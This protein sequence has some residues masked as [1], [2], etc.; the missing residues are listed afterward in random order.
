MVSKKLPV[1]ILGTG[2]I[3][4]DLLLKVLRSPV[5]ECRLFAGRNLSSSGMTKASMLNVPVSAKGVESI[6]DLKKE[7]GLVFDATS[8]E[9][10]IKHAP[11]FNR[12]GIVAVDLT[13]AKVGQMCVPAVNLDQC[14]D[15]PN[16]NMITCGGQ[17]SI[18]LAYA[19]A[20][21][22]QAIQYI[23]TVSSIASRSAG[24]ATRIN[25]DEYLDTTETGLQFFS[26]CPHTKAILNL[27][28]A[29]PCVH[30]QTTVMAKILN[31]DLDATRK[32]VAEMVALIRTY[33]PGYQLLLEPIVENGRLV[34]MVK[35][36][37]LGDY[38]PKYAGNLDIINC[39]AIAFAEALARRRVS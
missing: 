33:V 3:G 32:K 5:L 24:P 25:L 20:Q 31:P 8:A 23:E 19:I 29:Q 2:N 10:H 18:P 16:V 17:A 15:L 9:D 14:L 21:A 22:N 11:L 36:D 4:T 13:P 12:A 39:A 6:L 38:L 27:N 30:M 37:G 7:I 35:V 28:P 1:A 26:D 34:T